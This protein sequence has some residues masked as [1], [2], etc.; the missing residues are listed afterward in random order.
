MFTPRQASPSR[1]LQSN[2]NT[3][4]FFYSRC[5]IGPTL[6]GVSGAS[7]PGSSPPTRTPAT[8][9]SATSMIRPVEP[10]PTCI[11]L[12]RAL[13]DRRAGRR[14]TREQS[15]IQIPVSTFN[16]SRDQISPAH[17]A[18]GILTTHVSHPIF[19]FLP[20]HDFTVPFCSL[21]SEVRNITS[22]R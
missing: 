7:A 1:S 14:L 9:T 16:E 20:G 5:S 21:T 3:S 6:L 11:S 12:V 4:Q 18:Q 17:L 10:A 8:S 13:C 15:D 2:L 19:I 22:A